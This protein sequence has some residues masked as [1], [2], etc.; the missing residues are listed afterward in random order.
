[1]SGG[2][3]FYDTT[4]MGEFFEHNPVLVVQAD[5]LVRH[6]DSHVG[7]APVVLDLGCGAG[8][9]TKALFGSRPGAR[10]VGG[11]V[12][13]QALGR[14][15]DR[16]G[17]P[18][19]QLDGQALPFPDQTFDVVVAD[20]VIEHLVDTDAFAREVRRVL[21]PGGRLLLSTPNLAAWFNRIA[22]VLGLQPAFSEV[23]FEGIF[24]R[25]GD[26]VVGHLRLFTTR[27]L[28]EFLGHHGYDVVD[29]RGA[30][31]AGVQRPLRPLDRALA[32][33]PKLAGNAVVVA[34]SP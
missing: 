30:A 19:L 12:S 21:R 5:Q 26:D 18:G 9:T 1:V 14:Y 31:F 32:R 23:S 11:D 33:A 10:V 15:T 20:D 13:L 28:L 34:V 17:N 6:V 3:T 4:S 8:T 22:L 7:R 25:P 2:R 24:G 29:V 16:T 27:A